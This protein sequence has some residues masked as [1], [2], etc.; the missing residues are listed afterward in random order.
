MKFCLHASFQALAPLR[1]NPL[2]GQVEV[3][4]NGSEAASAVGLPVA[5]CQ[6]SAQLCTHCAKLCDDDA[7][8]QWPGPPAPTAAGAVCNAPGSENR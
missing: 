4:Q 2:P 3:T 5:S 8:T 1:A 6:Y 7:A